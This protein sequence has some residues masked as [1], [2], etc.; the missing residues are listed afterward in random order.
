MKDFELKVDLLE[1]KTSHFGWHFLEITDKILWSRAPTYNNQP[2]VDQK[3]GLIVHFPKVFVKF[4]EKSVLDCD[5][6]FEKK[7]IKSR[8]F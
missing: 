7:L 2:S 1:L 8:K 4:L 3:K 6:L 5:K